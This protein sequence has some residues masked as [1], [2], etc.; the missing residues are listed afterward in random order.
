MEEVQVYRYINSG[1]CGQVF[2]G[3]YNNKAVAIKK[4]IRR[5]ENS[6]NM[7]LRELEI[8]AQMNHPN[9]ISLYG[10]ILY[11]KSDLWIV[12]ELAK[13]DL[14]SVLKTRND[15]GKCVL[16]WET[17]KEYIHQVTRGLKYTIKRG[18]FHHDLKLDNLLVDAKGRLKIADFGLSTIMRNDMGMELWLGFISSR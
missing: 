12:M 18:I 14:K 5:D 6:L 2:E 10:Y 13:T 11:S 4:C 17:R 8:L 7:V 16:P 9:V 1:C 3:V 15:R